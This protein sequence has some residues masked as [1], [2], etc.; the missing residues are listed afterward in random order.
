MSTLTV[1]REKGDRSLSAKK[2]LGVA[3]RKGKPGYALACDPKLLA[4]NRRHCGVK[5]KHEPMELSS[6]RTESSQSRPIG[7]SD[8]MRMDSGQFIS[9]RW[10]GR[11]IIIRSF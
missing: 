10:A 6:L 9:S 4:I 11:F 1:Q 5:K 8:V 2:S 7:R 3:H